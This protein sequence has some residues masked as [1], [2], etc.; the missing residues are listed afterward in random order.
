MIFL[1]N[2]IF[3]HWEHRTISFRS[4]IFE[5]SL[6]LW[7]QIPRPT[8]LTEEFY[9]SSREMWELTNYPTP[10]NRVG[11]EMSII[12]LPITKLLTS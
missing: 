12:S 10:R 8:I 4:T 5:S 2:L 7:I 6:G 1:E 9:G 11:L 3:L